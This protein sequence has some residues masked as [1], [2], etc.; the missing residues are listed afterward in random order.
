MK[1]E[2]ALQKLL[3]GNKRFAERHMSHPDQTIE[4]QIKILQGQHPF[5]AILGCSDS[6]I[7]PEIIFDQGLGDLFIIRVAGNILDDIII[8]SIEYAVEHLDVNLVMVMGHSNC[9]AIRA[10]ISGSEVSL[11]T[12]Y[13]VKSLLPVVEKARELQG[14]IYENTTKLNIMETVEKLKTTPPVLDKVVEKGQVKI[15]GAYYNLETGLVELLKH[16]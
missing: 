5:A 15:V 14:D 11:N 13:I 12:G 3:E 7:P 9:G 10:T 1:Y 6:R 8:G 4:R 2:E 16:V